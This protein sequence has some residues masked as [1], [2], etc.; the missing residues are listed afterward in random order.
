MD[1]A[2]HRVHDLVDIVD[3]EPLLLVLVE[4]ELDTT[5]EAENELDEKEHKDDTSS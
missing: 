1:I 3:K 5:S 4:L 2:R